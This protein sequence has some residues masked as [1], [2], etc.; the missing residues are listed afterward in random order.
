MMATIGTRQLV[1]HQV[2]VKVI[3]PIS[4]YFIRNYAIVYQ[5]VI[6]LLY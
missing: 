3:K 4:W 5:P 2:S 1:L 6:I